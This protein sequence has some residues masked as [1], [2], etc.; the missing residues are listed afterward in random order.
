MSWEDGKIMVLGTEYSVEYR[1]EA[2]DPRLSGECAGYTDPS[3]HRIVICIPEEDVDN[4]EDQEE[5]RKRT[6]R[7]ELVHAFAFESGLDANSSWA[8]DEEM[9][10]WVANQAPKMLDAF[11][12]ADAM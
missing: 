9:T 4:C 1:R 8:M 6:L 7:H 3:V 5:T 11:G 2:E 12:R 10:A